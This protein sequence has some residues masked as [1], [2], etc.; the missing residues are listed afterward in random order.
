MKINFARK[1]ILEVEIYDTDYKRSE[2]TQIT[3]DIA[4]LMKATYM[5]SMEFV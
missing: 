1:P 2:K 3:R 5:N 4:E